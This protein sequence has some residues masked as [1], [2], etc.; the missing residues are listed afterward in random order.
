MHIVVR[1]D[2]DCCESRGPES[3]VTHG[4]IDLLYMYSTAV[5]VHL[6]SSH[7]R[8]ARRS[9]IPTRDQPPYMYSEYMLM[10]IRVPA[11]RTRIRSKAQWHDRGC[12][13]QHTPAE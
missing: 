8:S 9:T 3:H 12:P 7:A 10:Y 11:P 13:F 4:T 6:Y 1:V 5:Q 2:R